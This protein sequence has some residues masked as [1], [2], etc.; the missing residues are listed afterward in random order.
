MLVNRT[1][2][3][4]GDGEH[5]SAGWVD[6][7]RGGVFDLQD[8]QSREGLRK[9]LEDGLGRRVAS[10]CGDFFQRRVRFSQRRVGWDK[11]GGTFS[12]TKAEWGAAGLG[13]GLQAL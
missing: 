8:M 12:C 1:S 9:A 10:A 5:E 7:S 6:E 11:A 3:R 2:E 13:N 4:D